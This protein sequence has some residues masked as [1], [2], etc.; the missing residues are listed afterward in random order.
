MTPETQIELDKDKE[1]V[2]EEKEV[3]GVIR[4]DTK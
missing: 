2:R 1:S 3:I 4:S